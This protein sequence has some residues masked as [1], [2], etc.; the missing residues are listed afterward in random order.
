MKSRYVRQFTSTGIVLSLSLLVA[1]D[2][3][4]SAFIVGA[5]AL[6]QVAWLVAY[7]RGGD[8]FIDR[9]R[10]RRFLFS[11]IWPFAVLVFVLMVRQMLQLAPS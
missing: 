11:P 1:S 8:P 6:T 9:G 4:E 3:N 10:L 5:L 2:G 7:R